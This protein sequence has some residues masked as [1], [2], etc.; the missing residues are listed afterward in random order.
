MAGLSS[1]PHRDS[2]LLAL[3]GELL[4][5]LDRTTDPERARH[6]RAHLN[7]VEQAV[8]RLSTRLRKRRVRREAALRALDRQLAAEIEESIDQ[9][10][11]LRLRTSRS[12]VRTRTTR[13]SRRGR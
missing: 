8:E 11:V 2:A 4:A 6:L 10:E 1:R 5:E 12:I 3:Y 7:A 9:D 13:R